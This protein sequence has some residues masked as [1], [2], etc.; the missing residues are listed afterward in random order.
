MTACRKV[1]SIP[2]MKLAT[3]TA[4]AAAAA[5]A[6]SFTYQK[7]AEARDRRRFPPPGQ[8]VDIGGRC[9]H[10]MET[11]EGSPAVITTP[12]LGESVLG[13]L[14]VLQGAAAE[15]QACIYDRAEIGWSDPPPHWR[16]T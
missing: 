1:R 11:G 10:L 12:A 2:G 5:A 7:I 9:L 4:A 15:T 16:R 6:V 8:L 3:R 14:P 13:G